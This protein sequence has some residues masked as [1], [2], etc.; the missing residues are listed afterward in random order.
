M[1][2]VGPRID[3]YSNIQQIGKSGNID[4]GHNHAPFIWQI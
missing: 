4:M 2:R 3:P 1:T